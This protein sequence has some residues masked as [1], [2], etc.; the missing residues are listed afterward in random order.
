MGQFK[1]NWCKNMKFSQT[2][3]WVETDGQTATIGISDYAQKELGEIV[4]VELPKLGHSV[5]AKE[6]AVVIESTKAAVDIYSPISGEIIAVNDTLR[7]NPEKIN[8][9]AELEGWLFKL[10]LHNPQEIDLLMSEPA[11]RASQK[12]N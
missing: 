1:V 3:E 9:S 4:Y 12:Q 2:H 11:Y 5:K 8:S 7:E 10:R 6:E